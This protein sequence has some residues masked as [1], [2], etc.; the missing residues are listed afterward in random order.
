[1]FGGAAGTKAMITVGTA[2]AGL[3]NGR[4]GSGGGGNGGGGEGGGGA[5][6]GAAGWFLGT[7]RGRLTTLPE[8]RVLVFGV[9]L[10][11]LVC[12]SLLVHSLFHC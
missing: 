12:H 8:R 11:P 7:G 5:G 10:L 6:A 2:G 3:T 4:A 9:P 1:M